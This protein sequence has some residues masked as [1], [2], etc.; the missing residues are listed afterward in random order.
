MGFSIATITMTTMVSEM[1][2]K[3]LRLV[4]IYRYMGRLAPMCNVLFSS[5]TADPSDNCVKGWDFFVKQSLFKLPTEEK[6]I[7]MRPKLQD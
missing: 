3:S 5:H 1:S 6:G 7:L 4:L 2:K